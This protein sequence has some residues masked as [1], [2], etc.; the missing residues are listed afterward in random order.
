[1][2]KT[3][4]IDTKKQS[5]RSKSQKKQSKTKNNSDQPI[6]PQAVKQVV[7]ARQP[8]NAPK[9]TIIQK[10][11]GSLE[12]ITWGKKPEN[13][14]PGGSELTTQK[15]LPWQN[16]PQK[17]ELN[18]QIQGPQIESERNIQV[19]AKSQS[20]LAGNQEL[21]K[22]VD[23]TQ[24]KVSIPDLQPEPDQ[25]HQQTAES[26]QQ[27]VADQVQ[28][29]VDEV[30][31]QE[32]STPSQDTQ[33]V[34][35]QKEVVVEIP[36]FPVNQAES[37][38][39]AAPVVLESQV[40]TKDVQVDPAQPVEMEKEFDRSLES[41]QRIESLENEIVSLKDSLDDLRGKHKLALQSS[42]DENRRLKNKNQLL[43]D[44][45]K[46]LIRNLE[47]S[48]SEKTEIKTLLGKE[49][50]EKQIYIE[51]INGLK[52]KLELGN[53][54]IDNLIEKKQQL[55]STLE[56]QTYKIAQKW[57]QELSEILL[58]KLSVLAEKEPEPI[59]GLKPR[60]VYESLLDWLAKAFGERPR[61]FPTSKEYTKTPEGK[62]LLTLD[63]DSQ[64]TDG[65][66][67][68]YDWSPEQPFETKQLCQFKL[69]H[70]GWRVKDTILVRAR[71]TTFINEPQD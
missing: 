51:E 58:T 62:H 57:A 4:K 27:V 32:L 50:Q 7:T 46:R 29:K 19:D 12:N 38:K 70:W 16:E 26:I 21:I 13:L 66:L 3:Q 37:E 17:T 40:Q 69:L 30:D 8:V 53:H 33:D 11:K 48:E 10:L 20:P 14:H 23:D 64:G 35:M 43:K 54:T 2:S 61:M 25:L 24:L 63:A 31:N 15:E 34:V 67:K 5:H 28:I 52:S 44:D 41:K 65:L 9:E 47:L 6:K 68:Y 22:Q 39:T 1:M 18:D 45:S 42:D 59:I 60:A 71:V 49:R 55:E 36:A 56:E